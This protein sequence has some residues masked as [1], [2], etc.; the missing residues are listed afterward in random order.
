MK[1]GKLP[2]AAGMSQTD[3]AC[4]HMRL[5]ADRQSGTGIHTGFYVLM[6]KAGEAINKR[7]GEDIHE[8]KY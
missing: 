1:A 7:K 5:N 3:K 6:E 2:E 8:E 4:R